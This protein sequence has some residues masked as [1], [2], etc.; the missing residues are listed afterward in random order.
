MLVEISKTKELFNKISSQGLGLQCANKTKDV[1]R[2][3]RSEVEVSLVQPAR[4]TQEATQVTGHKGRSP[5]QV[6]SPHKQ[7]VFREFC[8]HGRSHPAIVATV[9]STNVSNPLSVKQSHLKT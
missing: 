5:P 4:W 8:G 3:L 1:R 6:L 2:V 9:T 7:L